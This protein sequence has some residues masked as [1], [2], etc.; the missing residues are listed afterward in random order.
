[1]SKAKFGNTSSTI[2]QFRHAVEPAQQRDIDAQIS[3]LTETAW[4]E[5]KEGY[6]RE[7]SKTFL[8]A[9]ETLSQAS[10]GEEN[11]SSL[12][13]MVSKMTNPTSTTCNKP[14]H[15]TNHYS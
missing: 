1:M 3:S 7:A 4:L 14:I 11:K 10:H 6:C 15:T 2:P 5:E 12:M 13:S 9:F 8:N